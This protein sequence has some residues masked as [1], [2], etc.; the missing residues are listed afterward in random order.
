MGIGLNQLIPEFKKID[1]FENKPFYSKKLSDVKY[2]KPKMFNVKPQPFS[3]LK[4]KI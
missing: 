4:K 3:I 2:I 1:W